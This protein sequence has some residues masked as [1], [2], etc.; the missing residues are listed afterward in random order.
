MIIFFFIIEILYRRLILLLEKCPRNEMKIKPI[1]IGNKIQIT[2]NEFLGTA[3]QKLIGFWQVN[4]E[5][6]S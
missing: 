5:I 2:D 3:V 6:E 1:Y 4:G